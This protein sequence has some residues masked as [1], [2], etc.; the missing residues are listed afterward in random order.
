MP[1]IFKF[2]SEAEERRRTFVLDTA[3]NHE[4][5]FFFSANVRQCN[6]TYSVVH[7]CKTLVLNLFLFFR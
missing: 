1:K 7:A 5:S 6:I 3:Q 2:C 4:N